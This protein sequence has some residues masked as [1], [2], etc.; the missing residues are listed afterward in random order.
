M[1]LVHK[2]INK[3]FDFA[4]NSF[5]HLIIENAKEFFNLTNELY[6]Q[7]VLGEDGFWVLSDSGILDLQKET[8]FISNFFDMDFNSKK[9][10]N[11]INNKIENE[12]KYNDFYK[13]FAEINLLLNKLNF[14]ITQR[15][16][17]P[18]S[19]NN[20][21]SFDDLIKFSNYKITAETDFIEKIISFIDI[22]TK[23]KK[24]K[25]VVLINATTYL[26]EKQLLQIF[27]HLK[28]ANLSAMLIDGKPATKI[29][30]AQTTIID[31]DLCEI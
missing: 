5:Q 28:Y 25:L 9:I 29:A 23:L 24:I 30:A 4:V 22:F 6:A 18:V 11:L 26:T 12:L 19:Y 8:L 15:I 31:P 14:D 21:F 3:H 13:E 20:E 10:Q 27:K 7:S 1:K 17:L 16:D 2:D